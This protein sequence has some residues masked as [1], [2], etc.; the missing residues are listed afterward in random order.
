[1]TVGSDVGSDKDVMAF[2]RD[3]VWITV[4]GHRQTEKWLHDTWL[5]ERGG[6]ASAS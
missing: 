4:P 6:F 3:I 2:E 1:V 5:T